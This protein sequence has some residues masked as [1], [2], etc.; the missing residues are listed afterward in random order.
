MR[1]RGAGKA[2]TAKSAKVVGRFLLR[3]AGLREWWFR[4]G[5][6]E[7]GCATFHLLCDACA[8]DIVDVVRPGIVVGSCIGVCG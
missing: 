2:A 4:E 8:V 7:R 5:D 1:G 3:G 6:Q